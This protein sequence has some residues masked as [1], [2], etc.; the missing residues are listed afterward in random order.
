MN[1]NQ[2]VRKVVMA[3]E[4]AV[5]FYDLA[6]CPAAGKLEENHDDIVSVC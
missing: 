5:V 3:V 1:V 4:I 2:I 6:C